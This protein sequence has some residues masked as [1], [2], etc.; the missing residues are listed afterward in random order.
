M[1]GPSLGNEHKTTHIKAT[2]Y[3]AHKPTQDPPDNWRHDLA[4]IGTAILVLIV[5][6]L[7]ASTGSVPAR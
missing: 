1:T 4:V 5:I 2:Y 7:L 6:A 3:Q